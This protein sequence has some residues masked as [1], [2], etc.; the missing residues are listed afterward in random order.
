MK[1]N[2]VIGFIKQFKS[3]LIGCFTL[4]QRSIFLIHD[5]IGVKLLARLRLKFSHLNEDKFRHNFKVL[6]PP[7][8]TVMLILKQSDPFSC[9]AN[10]L[11]MKKIISIMFLI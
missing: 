1:R 8:G 5:P 2:K 9:V 4:K 11:Q 6:K 10:S 3:M 7:C